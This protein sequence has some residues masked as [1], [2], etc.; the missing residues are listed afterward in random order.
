[1][2][3]L[4]Q[5]RAILPPKKEEEADEEPEAES[6]TASMGNSRAVSVGTPADGDLDDGLEQKGGTREEED[7]DETPS[8]RD[9]KIVKGVSSSARVE[10]ISSA[11]DMDDADVQE[12]D[13]AAVLGALGQDPEDSTSVDS[14]LLPTTD[15]DPSTI[16]ATSPLSILSP[17]SAHPSSMSQAASADHDLS[18]T[19]TAP[20]TP[21][22]SQTLPPSTTLSHSHT[23]S[24][25]PS[26]PDV[27]NP[28]LRS[29]RTK[30]DASTRPSLGSTADEGGK[31]SGELESA[32]P[33]KKARTEA[34]R[35]TLATT[36]TGEPSELI[37]VDS[38]S[39]LSDVPGE[40]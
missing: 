13:E 5:V 12:S 15:D 26:P 30:R 29:G 4:E 17:T 25:K 9:D 27:A 31:P 16:K 36:G 28:K 8:R 37:A 23:D 19:N 21:L 11:E 39:D 35:P 3:D 33:S 14:T 18:S 6:R 20:G 7:D 40:L 1:M 2:L 38:D 24:D 10:L 22:S 34:S 32:P